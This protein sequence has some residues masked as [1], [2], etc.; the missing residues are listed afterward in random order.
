VNQ[1]DGYIVRSELG[2]G[3]MATVYLAEEMLTHRLVALKVLRWDLARSEEARRRFITEMH[4]LT[5]LE[6]PNVVR[7]YH[8]NDV[9]GQLLMA[10]EYVRGGTLRGLLEARVRVD[11]AETCRIAIGILA[12]L[13]AAHAHA[14][15][16]I[17]RDLKPENILLGADGVIKVAD[18]GIAKMLGSETMTTTPLGTLHYMSPEQFEDLPATASS[19]LYSLGVVLYEMLAGQRPFPGRSTVEIIRAHHSQEPPPF[20]A[21]LARAIP[22][23]LTQLVFALLRKDPSKRP[24]SAHAVRDQLVR[25]LQPDPVPRPSVPQPSPPTGSWSAPPA[26]A[27]MDTV[28][29]IEQFDQRRQRPGGGRRI[30]IYAVAGAL[31]LALVGALGTTVLSSLA[32]H[33]PDAPAEPSGG[34]PPSPAENDPEPSP[35]ASP[36]STLPPAQGSSRSRVSKFLAARD[37]GGPVPVHPELQLSDY[38][39]KV[40]VRNDL[41]EAQQGARIVADTPVDGVEPKVQIIRRPRN[42]RIEHWVLVGRYRSRSAAMRAKASLRPILNQG[43]NHLHLSEECVTLG[44]IV[45]GVRDC[46][47]P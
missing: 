7:C 25:M 23:Q 40:M 10:L 44:P 20:P 47:P 34:E 9:D 13:E 11:A 1:I 32:E 27:P 8:C 45:D 17:H 39:V 21:E 26:R 41:L 46:V 42:G 16:V 31:S 37:P 22:P 24:P 30:A 4:I 43:A 6:H 3:G 28:Q 18:F 14:P 12:A 29:L 5:T 35:I 36:T 19:D 2:R 38:T 33:R 15:P